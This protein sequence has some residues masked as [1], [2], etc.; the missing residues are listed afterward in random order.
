MSF[1]LTQLKLGNTAVLNQ[2]SGFYGDFTDV[3]ENL[4]EA[5]QVLID[6]EQ[7]F[8]QLPLDVRQQFDNNF[9]NWLF[10]S[11]SPDWMKKMEKLIPVQEEKVEEE[12]SADVS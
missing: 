2:G 3:P 6:G 7:A 8:N 4:A 5:Q 1:I 9:R 10:T 12:V 11:G